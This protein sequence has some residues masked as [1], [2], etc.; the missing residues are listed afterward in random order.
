MGPWESPFWSARSAAS[1]SSD[2]TK[3]KRTHTGERPYACTT[4]GQAFSQSGDLTK[5][6]RTHD[7]DRPYPCTTCGMAFSRSSHLTRHCGKVHALDHA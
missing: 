4:C 1:T 6:M 7:G 2:L 3:H 5:H